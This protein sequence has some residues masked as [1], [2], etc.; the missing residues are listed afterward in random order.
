[1]CVSVTLMIHNPGPRSRNRVDYREMHRLPLLLS[2]TFLCVFTDCGHGT[3]DPPIAG[4]SRCRGPGFWVIQ[5]DTGHE[6]AYSVFLSFFRT[7]TGAEFQDPFVITALVGM[8]MVP[9]DVNLR[10]GGKGG[11]T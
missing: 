8:M 9:P 4:K 11:T 7:R 10:E 2:Y 6:E 1:M 3:C 5:G